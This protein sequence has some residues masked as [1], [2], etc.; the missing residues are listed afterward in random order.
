M[1]TD[2]TIKLSDFGTSKRLTTN[3]DDIKLPN[4]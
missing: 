2:G 4:D 3:S 1:D